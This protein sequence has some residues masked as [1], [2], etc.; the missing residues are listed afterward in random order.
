MKYK[1]FNFLFQSKYQEVD[2][3]NT[4]NGIIIEI[5][6]DNGGYWSKEEVLRSF[7]NSIS[8]T[9]DLKYN[10]YNTEEFREEIIQPKL[11]ELEEEYL[12]I[13]FIDEVLGKKIR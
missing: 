6:K 10:G 13:K 2:I 4:E 7:I 1:I 12:R 11:K 8:D 5:L 9:Y 3:I